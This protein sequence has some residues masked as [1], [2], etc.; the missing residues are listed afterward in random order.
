MKRFQS[1]IGSCQVALQAALFVTLLLSVTLAQEG[2][3]RPSTSRIKSREDA[4]TA[5]TS[6]G[7]Q[8]VIAADD[9]YRLA[10]SD[11]LEVIIEDAPELSGNYR[12]NRS[13]TLP[14]KYL[15]SI[16]VA[17]KTTEDVMTMVTEG[18]RGRYLRDPKVYVTVKQYNSRTFF[19][20]G[21]IKNP[22][23]FVIEGR[24]S[25][26]KL[27][28]IAGGMPENHGSTAYII[29]EKKV[30]PAKM[31]RARAG[32]P[33]ENDEKRP[34]VEAEEADQVGGARPT[35]P[36]PAS[37][38][39]EDAKSG[40]TAIDGE[41]EYE[42]LTAN[43]SGF[44]RGRFEQNLIIQPN[45][46]VYIPPSEVFFVVGEVK[47]PGQFTLREGSSIRQAISLS[48]GLLFK[49]ASDRA[50]IFRQDPA[51]GKL[52]EI[53]V[54]I[55]AIM[56]GKKDDVLLAPNDVVMIPNSKMKAFAGSMMMSMGVAMAQTAILGIMR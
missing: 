26:F 25:L 47:S 3:G 30:D 36:T 12:I 10:P 52:S 4:P 6:K 56:N 51:T 28:S 45:D 41:T 40:V 39:L 44:Y 55:G 37:R 19:I 35:I 13:G 50:M 54:D 34:A 2:G 9:D 18:L 27:I 22:G 15:G 14:M 1:S 53:P 38:A 23:V 31:E 17:G 21:A 29:R 42:L 20:Q 32:L 46:L 5:Q 16:Q 43:I 33:V 49:A 24:P 48:Q 8:V 11:V 7:P